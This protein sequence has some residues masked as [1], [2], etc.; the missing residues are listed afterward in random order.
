M[1]L[2]YPAYVSTSRPF[3]GTTWI[4]WIHKFDFYFFWLKINLGNHTNPIVIPIFTQNVLS[5]MNILNID[6]DIH[7]VFEEI[8]FTFTSII[9]WDT[10]QLDGR[11]GCWN[12][13][14]ITSSSWYC[15]QCSNLLRAVLIS[16]AVIY[17]KFTLGIASLQN[18]N[19]C[20]DVRIWPDV[21]FCKLALSVTLFTVPPIPSQGNLP[22]PVAKKFHSQFTEKSPAWKQRL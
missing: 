14:V 4:T 22:W 2:W 11:I 7:F 15:F 10:F 18:L 8:K 1:C 12:V 6:A 3:I 13:L 5:Y 17:T 20:Y 16:L 19:I 9:T 21:V